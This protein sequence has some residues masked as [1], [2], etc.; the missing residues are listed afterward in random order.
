MKNDIAQK[1]QKL[2]S[3]KNAVILAHNY[4][5]P[6]VQDIADF[7]GDSL[8]L[9][10]KAQKTDA[11]TIIFCGVDFMAESAKILNPEKNVI[12]PDSTAKCPMANMVNTKN[13]LKIKKEYPHAEVVA[14]IN[15]TAELKTHSTICCTSANGVEV[16]KSLSAKNVIFV[17]DQ[18]LGAY[19]QR[20]IPD[21]EM[22]IW[23]G[24]CLTHHKIRKEDI[25]KL[26]KEHPAAEILVHPEC[27]PEVID[28]ADHVFST[29]GMVKYAK[30]SD[31]TE[32]II[33]TEKEICYRL[34]KENPKKEFYPI[35]YAV[36]QNMKKITIDKVL[37]SLETLEPKI[38]LSEDIMKNAKKPL[39]RMMDMR[40]GN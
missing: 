12:I 25:L 39:K 38:T 34:K 37:K 14:Y 21:K 29:N 26:K 33:C 5:L 8:D 40:R 11:E 32:F 7:L 24:M 6:E 15:T 10:K 30:E 31:T 3:E 2:K 16:V 13:L 9:A 18:N 35:K 23:P 36:C 22:I 1:I 19:I 27:R 20:Q 17:P 4:Q 28:I